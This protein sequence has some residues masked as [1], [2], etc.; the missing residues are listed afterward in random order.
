MAGGRLRVT[1]A[2]TVTTMTTSQSGVLFS[3]GG[4][5]SWPVTYR[6]S[7]SAGFVSGTIQ[8]APGARLQTL[9]PSQPVYRRRTP[10]EQAVHVLES[11]ARG[12]GRARALL[13]HDV[14]H[15]RS[16]LQLLARLRRGSTVRAMIAAIYARKS[17]DGP[18]SLKKGSR[19]RFKSRSVVGDNPAHD[20]AS[21]VRRPGRS[22]PGDLLS[23]CLCSG[24]DS[25]FL[26]QLADRPLLLGEAEWLGVFGQWR[27][28]TPPASARERPCLPGCWM[29]L[30]SSKLLASNRRSPSRLSAGQTLRLGSIEL[31]F[32]GSCLL[33]S[34]IGLSWLLARTT[35]NET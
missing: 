6:L 32:A 8:F 26:A 29:G 28:A 21:E 18:A 20:P 5:E 13:E 22:D 33:V 2:A 12:A 23:P 4:D 14:H 31:W 19:F 27:N 15:L 30:A 10:G 7:T 25:V 17:T 16:S 3:T 24:R 1:H 9:N 34:L 11:F 35:R